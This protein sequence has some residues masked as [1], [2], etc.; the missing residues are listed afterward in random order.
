VE[1]GAPSQTSV[2]STAVTYHHSN[3]IELLQRCEEEGEECGGS[4]TDPE[5]ELESLQD[6][7]R[8]SKDPS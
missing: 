2:A 7:S 4:A 8:Q 3:I 1:E 6:L 5:I